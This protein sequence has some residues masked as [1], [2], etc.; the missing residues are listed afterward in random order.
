MERY[1][2]DDKFWQ[3]IGEDRKKGVRKFAHRNELKA[4]TV[5]AAAILERFNED[6]FQ[7]IYIDKSDDS[8]NAKFE[9]SFPKIYHY[10][11]SRKTRIL[12]QIILILFLTLITI[13]TLN[14][15]SAD[16]K[17]IV[18]VRKKGIP[19]YHQ[20]VPEDI[21]ISQP[22]RG[23]V[24]IG[25]QEPFVGRYVLTPIPENSIVSEKDLLNVRLNEEMGNR[26]IILLPIKAENIGS[27]TMPDSKIGLIFSGTREIS[28]KAIIIKEIILLGTEKKD[29]GITLAVAMTMEQLQAIQNVLAVS[30][31]YVIKN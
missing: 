2:L 19:A 4:S 16:T 15:I 24:N 13:A 7:D 18:V 1:K 25:E 26:V 28:G 27:L 11:A 6:S 21:N 23:F 8:E 29:T 17:Q 20:I 9:F 12:F 31:V 3:K 5:L 30:N 14:L 10:I 22:F